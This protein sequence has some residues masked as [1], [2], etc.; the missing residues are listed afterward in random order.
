MAK[1]SPITAFLTEDEAAKLTPAAAQLTAGDLL[2]AM[3][4]FKHKKGEVAMSEA[5]S[6]LT[7]EDWKSVARAF[8]TQAMRRHNS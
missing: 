2:A 1:D 5:T 8:V 4:Q 6:G 7:N 3:Q